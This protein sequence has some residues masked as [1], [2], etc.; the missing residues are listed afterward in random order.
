MVARNFAVQELSY[1]QLLHVPGDENE[2]LTLQELKPSD[3]QQT[4]A[5]QHYQSNYYE[6]P[7]LAE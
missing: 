4:L 2:F 3:V 5:H 1:S 6:L 7:I